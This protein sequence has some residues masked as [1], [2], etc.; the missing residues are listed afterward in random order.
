MVMKK[1]LRARASKGGLCNGVSTWLLCW[2]MEP[3]I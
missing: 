3:N 2:P 1:L